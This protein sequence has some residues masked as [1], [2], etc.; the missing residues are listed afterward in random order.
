MAARDSQAAERAAIQA[1]RFDAQC[2]EWKRLSNEAKV[3]HQHNIKQS[4][5]CFLLPCYVPEIQP[6]AD[7]LPQRRRSSLGIVI[8]RQWTVVASVPQ[9]WC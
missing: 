4:R 9:Y 1:G 3:G 7:H 5:S 6:F 8:L 2:A